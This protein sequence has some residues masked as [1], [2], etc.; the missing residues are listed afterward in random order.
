MKLDFDLNSVGGGEILATF[1]KLK[2]NVD[3]CDGDVDDD[4]DDKGVHRA[5]IRHNFDC[6]ILTFI[7]FLSFQRSI[8]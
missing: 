6:P 4:G 3:E 5:N 8:K 7:N 1:E 2:K